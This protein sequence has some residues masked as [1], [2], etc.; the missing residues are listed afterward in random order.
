[1]KIVFCLQKV[2]VETLDCHDFGYYSR[3]NSNKHGKKANI[4]KEAKIEHSNVT[5]INESRTKANGA[6]DI[7][8]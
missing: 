7:R 3:R 5:L 6:K 8:P 2:K 4:I 1:M